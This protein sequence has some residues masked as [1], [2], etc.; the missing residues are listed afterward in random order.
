MQEV[1]LL[2]RDMLTHDIYEQWHADR[3]KIDGGTLTNTPAW[4][5]T[6]VVDVVCRVS[7]G[8]DH[9]IWLKSL[10]RTIAASPEAS[11]IQQFALC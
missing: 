5:G 2:K 9:N 6:W 10:D 11:V 7:D 1:L 3:P 4:P 8:S